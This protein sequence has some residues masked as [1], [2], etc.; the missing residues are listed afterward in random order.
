MDNGEFGR[1]STGLYA[2]SNWAHK[3]QHNTTQTQP[4]INLRHLQAAA[5][6]AAECASVVKRGSAG[7]QSIQGMHNAAAN[8]FCLFG[9]VKPR[10]GEM[11][12]RERQ[13]R[14]Q[15]NS[16]ACSL[17]LSPHLCSFTA[18]SFSTENTTSTHQM[19][20]ISRTCD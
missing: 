19:I 10:M 12:E 14:Q 2:P 20:I 3:T 8:I 7:R 5:C 16:F 1:H 11:G 13:R 6:A 9:Q 4:S 17:F 18:F 15:P